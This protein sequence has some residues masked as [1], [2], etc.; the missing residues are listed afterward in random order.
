MEIS[1]DQ[2][3]G[4]GDYADIER[5]SLYD[6]HILALSHAAALN[7]F[8]RIEDIGN[9]TESFQAQQTRSKKTFPDFIQK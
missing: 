2:L 1:Q 6:V 5:Q 7:A 3:F 8:D 4:E 9:M